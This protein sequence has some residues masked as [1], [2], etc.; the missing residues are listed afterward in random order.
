MEELLGTKLRALY[1]RKKGRDLFDVFYALRNAD[2]DIDKIIHCYNEYMIFSDGK[3]ATAREF[4]LNMDDKILD[5]TFKCDILWL[6]ITD[7]DYN[8]D[9]AYELIKKELLEKI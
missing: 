6:F 9:E 3:A 7:L 4:I 5:A 1:Q 8:I 2:V